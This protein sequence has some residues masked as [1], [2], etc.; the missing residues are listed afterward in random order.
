[1]FMF[2]LTFI[3]HAVFLT[4]CNLQKIIYTAICAFIYICIQHVSYVKTELLTLLKSPHL[5]GNDGVGLRF[6]VATD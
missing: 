6:S 1:M 3:V 2:V 5:I 4:T